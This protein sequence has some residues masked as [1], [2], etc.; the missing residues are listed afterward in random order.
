VHTA[1]ETNGV[2]RWWA[3]GEKDIGSAVVS[4]CRELRIE[5]TDR[6]IKWERAVAAYHGKCGMNDHFESADGSPMNAIRRIV[7]TAFAKIAAKQRPKASFLSAGGTYQTRLMCRKLSKFCEAQLHVPQGQFETSWD[8]M[9][10]VF[11]DGMFGG[12]GVVKV[13]AD[14][15]MRRIAHERCFAHEL[16]VDEKDAKYGAPKNLFQFH[17]CDRYNLAAAYPKH[18][19]AI[20]RAPHCDDG[21]GFRVN[22]DSVRVWEAWRLPFGTDKNGKTLPG[23]HVIALEG[24]DGEEA[25]LFEEDWTRPDFPFL[26]YRWKRSNKGF[27]GESFVDEMVP[28]QGYLDEMFECLS[29]N[30]Q[31]Q[32]SGVIFYVP[33]TVRNEAA[34]RGNEAWKMV[35]VDNINGVKMETP[36]PFHPALVQWLKLLREAIHDDTGISETSSQGRKEPGLESGRALLTMNQMQDGLFLPQ[37]RAFEGLFRELARKDVECA[38]ALKASGHKLSAVLP[39]EGFLGTIDFDEITLPSDM[40]TV[41]IQTSNSL[42]NSLAGR[43]QQIMEMG[44]AK[45]IDGDDMQRLL[46]SS[47]PDLE[48]NQ[49][50]RNAQFEYMERIIADFQEYKPGSGKPVVPAPD[51]LLDLNA[52]IEQMR[53]GYHEMLEMGADGAVDEDNLRLARNWIASAREIL[54]REQPAPAAGMGAPQGAGMPPGAQPSPQG[55]PGMPPGG[56]MPPQQPPPQLAAVPG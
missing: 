52:A 3:A 33:G 29:E 24:A 56:A 4:L 34:L 5:Q 10:Q 20:M 32:S 51:P 12:T 19:N 38:I 28:M 41:Q 22:G 42:E 55:P 26:F 40:Y 48:Q 30:A 54:K 2:N 11:K 39:D 43:R 1:Y 9:D 47:N 45:A 23:K 53:M 21:E 8:L 6:K 15:N 36:A 17:D 31:L 35:P 46:L 49:R 50:V 14:I 16:L 18:R 37:S 13:H 7:D 25:T 27:W 44:Q